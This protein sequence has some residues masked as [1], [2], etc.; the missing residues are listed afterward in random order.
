MSSIPYSTI[1]YAPPKLHPYP[2]LIVGAGT[3]TKVVMGRLSLNGRVVGTG[4]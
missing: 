3:I 2:D 1:Q 4:L